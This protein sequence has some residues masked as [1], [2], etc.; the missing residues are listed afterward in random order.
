M[1]IGI[2]LSQFAELKKPISGY[3]NYIIIVLIFLVFIDVQTQ[4]LREAL[5]SPKILGFIWVTNFLIIPFLGYLIAKLCLPNQSL[6]A[7]G[8]VI[9]FMSPC[10]DW[11][12]GFTR[13]ASGNTALGS[14]LLPINMLT[15]LLLYPFYL[16]IFSTGT[17]IHISTMEISETLLNWFLIPF[18][19][20]VLVKFV[21]NQLPK[22][23]NGI[24]NKLL[25][26]LINIA[27]YLLIVSIFAIYAE[28][29]ASHYEEF[30][31]VFLAVSVFFFVNSLL[32][33]F[34]AKKLTFNHENHVLY[35]MTTSARNAPLM[36][37]LTVTA[38]PDQSIV[39]VAIILGMLIE[40]PFL[41]LLVFRF[42]W[43]SNK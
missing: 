8:V 25:N 21:L 30:A 16:N 15:Q 12:L 38:L 13:M 9:Y 5:T 10:T 4:K 33:D 43:Q 37:G 1:L 39:H 32:V 41:T 22:N 42:N 24:I 20:A 14:V 17:E 3:L 19:V 7:L 35:S 18:I 6:L 23:V 2:L 11:F 36:L 26:E 40:L 31:M 27:I 34:M 29:I 28:E